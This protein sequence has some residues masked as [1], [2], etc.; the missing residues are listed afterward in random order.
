MS[1]FARVW[2]ASEARNNFP[3]V[4]NSALAGKPQTIRRR[5][6]EEVVVLSKPN[7]DALKPTLKSFLTGGGS[8]DDGDDL[9]EAIAKNQAEGITMLGLIR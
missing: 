7:Y 8:C 6:G 9:E 5:S 2:Q 3:E 1:K 4:M